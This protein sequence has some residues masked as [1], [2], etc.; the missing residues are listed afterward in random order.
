MSDIDDL[1]TLRAQFWLGHYSMALEEGKQMMRRTSHKEE[2]AFFSARAAHMLGQS[3]VDPTGSNSGNSSLALQALEAAHNANLDPLRS[4]VSQHRDDARVTL[5]AAQTLLA[6]GQLKEALA[7]VYHHHSTYHLEHTLTCLQIYL[8]MNRLDLARDCLKGKDE[9]HILVQLGMVY[10]SLYEGNNNKNN[11]ALLL[12]GLTE[13][14]G[15]SPY[16]ANLTAC[17]SMVAGNYQ[18]ALATL[19]E[20]AQE[21]ENTGGSCG[22]DTIHNQRVALI[23]AQGGGSD[24]GDSQLVP[25]LPDTEEYQRVVAAFDREAL[26]YA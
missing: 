2:C 26:K 11:T 1:Y 22:A 13:Q 15:V 5:V 19:A 3:Y 6:H 20:H 12:L 17:A 16:L 14:Y 21:L 24:S 7:L 23:H 4:L 25:P 10:L 9:D 8:A 18:E